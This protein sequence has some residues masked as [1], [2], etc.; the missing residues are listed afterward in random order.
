MGSAGSTA[1]APTTTSLPQS[2]T[3]TTVPATSSIESGV[4]P[5]ESTIPGPISD[6]T[7]D[8]DLAGV[9]NIANPNAVIAVPKVTPTVP[10]C[11]TTSETATLA[12]TLT[13]SA[14][15]FTQTC[16][17]APSDTTISVTLTNDITN[18]DTGL[19]YP[20]ALVVTPTSSPAFSYVG[21]AGS[22]PYLA[23]TSLAQRLQYTPTADTSAPIS[24]TIGPLAA[25]TYFIQTTPYEAPPAL[26]TVS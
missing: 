14:Q 9:A 2:S 24:F 23:Q 5:A 12:L 17:S 26:I 7:Y 11:P 10:S 8:N 25:G 18:T 15:G 13:N 20:L 21:L 22:A 3:T 19:T 4:P 1:A 16:Y 6:S